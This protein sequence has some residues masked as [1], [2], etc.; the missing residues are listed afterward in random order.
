MPSSSLRAVSGSPASAFGC[1][2]S[3][4]STRCSRNSNPGLDEKKPGSAVSLHF[5]SAAIRPASEAV[6]WRA[7]ARR[8]NWRA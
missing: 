5:G 3:R 4:V 1:S 7:S 2:R 8:Y 6:G